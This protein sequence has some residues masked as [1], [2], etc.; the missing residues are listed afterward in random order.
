MTTRHFQGA[1]MTSLHDLPNAY[2]NTGWLH[3]RQW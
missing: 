2:T 1:T 3:K